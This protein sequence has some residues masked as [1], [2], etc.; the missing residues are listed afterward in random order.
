MF[1]CKYCGYSKGYDYSQDE[2]GCLFFLS[3]EDILATLRFVIGCITRIS[4]L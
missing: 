4:K 2:Q 1:G 3:Y